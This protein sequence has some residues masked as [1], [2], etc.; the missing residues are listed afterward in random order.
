MGGTEFVEGSNPGQYWLAAN[1][2]TT[3]ASAL[4]YIPETTWN[5]SGTASLAA[6]GGGASTV[7][8]KPAWQTGAGVPAD[9]KRDVPD[10]S[11]TAAI[12][13]GYTVVQGGAMG[14]IFQV[15]GTSASTPS[16]AGLIA[17]VN[18]KYNSAQGCINPVLYPLAAKQAA[19]GASIFHDITTGNNSVPGLTGFS[20]ATGYDQATGLG[21]VDANILVNHWN[22]AAAPSGSLTISTYAATVSQGQT[23]TAAIKTTTNG[24]NSAVALTVSGHTHWRHSEFFSGHDCLP[25]FG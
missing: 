1:N 16:F 8:T 23:S 13:D 2:S 11:M 7:Y 22:D 3:L 19:G 4:S 18:Q 20:A 10:V 15:G 12:H 25:W 9:G 14:Y 17:L 5:E 6:G 24:I 21:S